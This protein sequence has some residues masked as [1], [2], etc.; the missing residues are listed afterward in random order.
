MEALASSSTRPCR[1]PD[2]ARSGRGATRPIVI[3]HANAR[4]R[5]DRRANATDDMIRAVASS[6]GVVGVCAAPFFLARDRPATLDMLID[7]AA[8]IAELVGPPMSG[9]ASTFADEDEDDYV[10]YGYDERWIP[11]PPWVWPEG[12]A[13]HAEAGNIAPALRARG[14][15]EAEIRG[16][17]G[18]NF[19]RVFGE[20]WGRLICCGK[21]GAIPCEFPMASFRRKP[22]SMA[23]QRG[24]GRM[25]PGFRRDDGMN[26]GSTELGVD[27]GGMPR[28]VCSLRQGANHG[29][30]VDH[31]TG[32]GAAPIEPRLDAHSCLPLTPG[33]SMEDLERH[34]AAGVDSSRSMSGWT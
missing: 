14:F 32:A 1:D 11:K 7:H 17:L 26:E 16:I 24:R 13:G 3:S 20:I 34:R 9:S 19:L 5:F 6:G 30:L 15:A 4:A 29:G 2:D 21:S 27:V 25:D 31:G 33:A 23:V 22:E 8:Y 18:E 12:I 28:R 10:Y